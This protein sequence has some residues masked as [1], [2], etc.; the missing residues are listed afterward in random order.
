MT[1]ISEAAVAPSQLATA[2]AAGVDDISNNQRIS[3]QQ[4][5]KSTLPT[6]GYVFWVAT[7]TAQQFAGSLHVL[8]ERKQ[9]EDQTLA[10]NQFVFTAE[11]EVSQL[12]AISP[13]TMW[14]GTWQVDGTALQIA[15]SA[16]G[17]N[18]QQAG[19]WHYRGFAVYP[20]LASQ[21]VSSAGDLPVG[22]IVSN[23]LP[24]WLGLPSQS[25]A[26]AP[27]GLAPIYASFL[28]PDNVV[29]P[30]IAVHIDPSQTITQQAMPYFDWSGR[31]NPNGDPSPVY[32]VPSFQ[33]MRDTVKL[34]FY[35]FTN[36]QAIQFN[37]A[38]MDYSVNSDDFG[39]GNSPAIVDD[40]RTQVEIASLAMKKTY[41]I[42]A[43]YN[44]GTADAIARR[45]IL[46]TGFSSITT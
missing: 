46:S 31:S 1:I 27:F 12:N 36:Q 19:L 20:A 16:T 17:F 10:A 18:Y 21:L 7:G 15:F 42:Q 28:V 29:P 40:K 43:S 2:L 11:E 5:T 14:V 24:I 44:S 39:F 38:L 9:E 32:D 8:S 30:Y 3:F 33:L 6:D 45:L 4:Y 13:G 26:Y 34:T 22:P 25:A 35:G 41:V 37:A 23:S